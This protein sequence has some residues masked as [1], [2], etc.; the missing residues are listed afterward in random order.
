MPPTSSNGAVLAGLRSAATVAVTC[1]AAVAAFAQTAAP[2]RDAA[3]LAREEADIRSAR[4]AQTRAMALDDLDK[5]VTWWAPE[6]TIRRALGQPVDG[7]E[8][9]RK[10]LVPPATPSPNRLIYQREPVAVQVSP[11]WPLA[12]EEGRWSGHP[13]S[14]TNAPVIG[15][16]YSAQWVKRDGRWLIRSEVFVALTCSGAACDIPAAP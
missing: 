4:T 8:A 5:V 14:V 7:A 12:Y 6:I 9:A 2:A 3:A 13:G 10:L 11:H 16:R 1:L 15:G